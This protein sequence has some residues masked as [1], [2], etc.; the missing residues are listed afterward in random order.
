MTDYGFIRVSTGDQVKGIE[1][2]SRDIL[3]VYPDAIIVRTDTKAASA[4]KGEQLDAMDK[5]IAK[6]VPGDRV[7][8]TDSSRLDRDPDQWAQMA[9]L[10]SIKAKGAEVAD[11][12]NPSFGASDRF[13]VVMTALH[14]MENADKSRTVKTQT[15]RGLVSIRDNKA[16]C[17][18]LPSFW[19]AKGAKFSK[20]AACTDPAAVAD[21]YQRIADG[22]S[23]ASVALRHDLYPAS[24]KTLIRFAANHTGI[25]QCSYS[26]AGFPELAWSH[27]VDAV[28]DSALWWRANKAI[29]V[30]AEKIGRPVAYANN[31]I[32]GVLD[33]P[34][35]GGKLYLNAGHTPQGYPRTPKLRCGGMGKRR[36]SC[37]KFT[38]CDAAP[39]IDAINSM[40]SADATQIM[41]F[42]R[43]SGN[44]HE[45]DELQATHAA[46]TAKL[47]SVDDDDELDA[48]V[49]ERKHLRSLIASFT[50][51]P[52]SFDYAPTGQTVAQM[53]AHGD[54]TTK[55]SMLR[56]VKTVMGLD[57][58]PD[59]G[60][61][62]D[63]I[64][65]GIL[66]AEVNT[67][68]I[69]DLGGGICFKRDA[70]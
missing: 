52:D 35:C 55:R 54:D 18:P 39:V 14:Q 34:E 45:L 26:F 59:Q 13:G 60:N 4:S 36:I 23:I 7:I 57:L 56:A 12:S 1:S 67:D 61:A 62:D 9:R 25:I 41:A 8:V 64:Y 32:S 31:W 44:A 24:V 47:S 38:G 37:G 19:D 65:V 42:Q 10:I 68:G 21:I 49:A 48:L 30:R 27:K 11:L 3:T 6:L 58:N 15:H 28:I 17:G 40:F 66:P 5:L 16:F 50:M 46:L 2:Q 33:C 53:W 70:A 69:V 63:R 20:Q 29:Q 51:V 43:V 22:E